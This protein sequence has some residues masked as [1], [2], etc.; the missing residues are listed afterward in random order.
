MQSMLFCFI[1]FIYEQGRSTSMWTSLFCW[2]SVF[3]DLNWLP[4]ILQI[5]LCIL[6]PCIF[7]PI[8][9]SVC[10]RLTIKLCLET[11]TFLMTKP[12]H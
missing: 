1:Y 11:F 4:H 8:L 7:Y 3:W 10:P 6:V 5:I 2:V 12:T 9:V